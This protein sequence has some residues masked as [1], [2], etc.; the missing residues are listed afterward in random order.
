MGA[1]TTWSL[2]THGPWRQTTRNENGRGRAIIASNNFL[3]NFIGPGRDLQP[4]TMPRALEHC[5][6]RLSRNLRKKQCGNESPRLMGQGKSIFA[7]TTELQFM[8]RHLWGGDPSGP[9]MF[10]GRPIPSIA[11]GVCSMRRPP[12]Q[13]R[14][15]RSGTS[16]NFGSPGPD[17]L[18]QWRLPA[19]LTLRHRMTPN[20]EVPARSAAR[21]I[22][23]PKTCSI[24]PIGP[25][26]R[27]GERVSAA[28]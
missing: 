20:M 28:D 16:K 13:F 11:R 12:L 1:R 3:S 26:V 6:A 17:L 15:G 24:S 9:Q 19:W 21:R 2:K 8:R 10:P 7:T 22:R 25:A 27:S 4:G 18:D 5:Q 23:T 14:S